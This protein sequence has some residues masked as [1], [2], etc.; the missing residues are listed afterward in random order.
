M[1]LCVY[2]ST[3][4]DRYIHF[5]RYIDRYIDKIDI[6]DTNLLLEAETAFHLTSTHT[7]LTIFSTILHLTRVQ[8]PLL[9]F[10]R[11]KTEKS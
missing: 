11:K 3:C 1:S 10:K 2:I 4:I 8:K 7:N 9:T 6:S 5:D